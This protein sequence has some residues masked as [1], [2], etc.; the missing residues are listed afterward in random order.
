MLV[1]KM[2][3]CGN[4]YCVI[5]YDDE[6]DFNELAIKLCNRYT[7]IGADGLIV[8][9]DDPIELLCYNSL[10]E[11]IMLSGSSVFCFTKY[12]LEHDMIKKNKLNL[13]SGGNKLT[14]DVTSRYPFYC[15]AVM[16]KP[17][18]SN[19]MLYISDCIDSFGRVLNLEDRT[20]TVYS[21]F[22]GRVHTVVFV[23]DFESELLSYA[24]K[25]SKHKIFNRF[26]NVSFVQIKNRN[27]ISV[28]TYEINIGFTKAS[29]TGACASVIAGYKL[30]LINS[31]VAVELEYGTLDIEYIKDTVYITGPAVK[32]F[33]CEYEGE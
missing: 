8:V 26:T 15:K 4:D 6:L 10:G 32:T 16:G 31:N 25:I 27:K 23:P 18:F 13:I 22:F 3:S 21:L 17:N 19:S 24:E 14:V 20:I 12:C 5:S 33:E 7:G 28:K 2:H 30:D 29:A 9:K 11:R 1:W